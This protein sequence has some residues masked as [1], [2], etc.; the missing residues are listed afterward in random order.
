[1]PRRHAISQYASDC[2]AGCRFACSRIIP[3]D[4]PAGIGASI[5]D[6]LLYGCGDAVIGINPATDSIETVVRLLTCWPS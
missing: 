6:G 4:D 5:L 3:T 1:M 2:P